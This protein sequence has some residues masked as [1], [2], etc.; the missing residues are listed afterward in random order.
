MNAHEVRLQHR[1]FLGLGSDMYLRSHCLLRLFLY[2]SFVG[3]S[4]KQ[5]VIDVLFPL[6]IP[7]AQVKVPDHL[8]SFG[9]SRVHNVGPADSALN[10]YG[11]SLARHRISLPVTLSN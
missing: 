3:G 2:L 5:V 4:G 1:S 6:V 7:D 9:M 11:I 10:R 8:L